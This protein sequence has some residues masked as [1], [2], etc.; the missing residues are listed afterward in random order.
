MKL[1]AIITLL[2]TFVITGTTS[3]QLNNQSKP[4]KLS[5]SLSGWIVNDDNSYG[6]DIKNDYEEWINSSS[7]ELTASLRK[8]NRSFDLSYYGNLSL[9]EEESDQNNYTNMLVFKIRDFSHDKYSIYFD[10]ST[11]FK[12]N[13]DEYDYYNVNSFGGRLLI[14]YHP[15]Y[16][17]SFN[18][19]LSVTHDN[20]L[21]YDELDNMYYALSLMGRKSFKSRFS[22]SGTATLSVK[23]YINQTQLEYLRDTSAY[24]NR[25]KEE[26]VVATVFSFNGQL[27]KSL[28]NRTGVSLNFG[29][30]R[31]L[32]SPIEVFTESGY[33]YTENDIYD[34]P[35][36]YESENLGLQL[37]RQFTVS[38]LVKVSSQI[39]WKR[40]TGTPA[41]DETGELV[42]E[43]REDRRAEVNLFASKSFLPKFIN[44]LELVFSFSFTSRDNK[45]NDAYNDFSDNT[46]ALG[47]DIKF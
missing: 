22:L 14:K 29:G 12:R 19:S 17:S 5:G 32:G 4:V 30:Q 33:Y 47:M 34:D 26:A 2:V 20:Y 1:R 31:F 3:A 8:P 21:I 41:L 39:A 38:F 24:Y 13:R 40:Y 6:T 44:P 23:D 15:S 36:S 9:F 25:A 7:L 46:L 43:T 35:S 27:A 37:T 18:T 28:S 45:S 42:G 16:Y 11:S 10:A